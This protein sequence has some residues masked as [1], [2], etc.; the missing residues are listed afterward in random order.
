[1]GRGGPNGPSVRVSKLSLTSPCLNTG[2]PRNY[3]GYT[4]THGEVPLGV[5]PLVFDPVGLEQEFRRG[6]ITPIV[7]LLLSRAFHVFPGSCLEVTGFGH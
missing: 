2:G 6:P 3:P 4:K 1:M 7:H 5:K